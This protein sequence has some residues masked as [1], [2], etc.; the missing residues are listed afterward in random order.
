[1]KNSSRI[2][3]L[4]FRR[5]RGNLNIIIPFL[6]AFVCIL[7]LC[8]RIVGFIRENDYTINLFEIFVCIFNDQYSIVLTSVLIIAL[9]HNVPEMDSS[10][11]YYLVRTD[12]KRWLFGQILYI[13]IVCFVCILFVIA[14]SIASS[15]DIMYLKDIWSNFVFTL[16]YSSLSEIINIDKFKDTMSFG[17]P[18]FTALRM[19][20]LIYLYYLTLSLIILNFN[21]RKGT[22]KGSLAGVVFSVFG[23]LMS[24]ATIAGIFGLKEMTM[25]KANVAMSWISPLNHATYNMHNFGYDMRPRI[26]HSYIVF[27]ILIVFLVFMAFRNI[28]NY[29]F[30]FSDRRD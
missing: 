12:C 4:N 15:V 25:Y 2:L 16:S 3:V 1:M 24:P 13:V 9:F 6:L 17:T 28:R 5:W 21:L 20:V 26:W 27:I 14:S 22:R 7:M 23:I 30:D 8:S 11:P 18:S 29:E 10:V 19:L